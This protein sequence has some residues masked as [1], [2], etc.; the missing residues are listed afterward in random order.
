MMLRPGRSELPKKV[1]ISDF[2]E[3]IQRPWVCLWIYGH[4]GIERGL[5]FGVLRV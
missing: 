3:S 1:R 5:G 2:C 4:T